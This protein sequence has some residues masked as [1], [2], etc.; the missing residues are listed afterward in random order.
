MEIGEFRWPPRTKYGGMTIDETPDSYLRWAINNW[1]DEDIVV[2]CEEELD[3][4]KL[5]GTTIEG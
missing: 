1:E 4:R 2:L 3:W 5:N